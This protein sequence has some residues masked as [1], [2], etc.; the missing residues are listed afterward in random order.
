[1]RSGLYIPR[2]GWL[3]LRL[4]SNALVQAPPVRGSGARLPIP[5]PP[6]RPNACRTELSCENGLNAGPIVKSCQKR[7]ALLESSFV[8]SILFT[9]RPRTGTS[10]D[11]HIGSP[12]IPRKV[13]RTSTGRALQLCSHQIERRNN[14]Y[15]IITKIAVEPWF[16][17]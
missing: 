3:F 12:V 13:N 10:G 6:V 4:T 9:G 14:V 7:G 16:Y 15:D 5:K 11:Y 8:F 2:R 1:M 17:F